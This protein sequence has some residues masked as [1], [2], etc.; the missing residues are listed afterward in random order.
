[1]EFIMNF[2][3]LMQQIGYMPKWNTLNKAILPDKILFLYM[4]PF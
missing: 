3:Q 2:S 4:L 1:M